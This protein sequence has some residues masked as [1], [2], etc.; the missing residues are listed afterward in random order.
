M[1]DLDIDM[2]NFGWATQRTKLYSL[3]Y[4]KRQVRQAIDDGRLSAENRTWVVHPAAN[5][6]VVAAIRARGALTHAS[7][8]RSFG[9]WVSEAA[10]D[11]HVANRRTDH[12]VRVPGVRRHWGEFRT[13]EPCHWRVRLVDAL[14]QYLPET[15]R[16]NAVATL[17]SALRLRLLTPSALDE[18]R[19]SL[20]RR[21]IGWL[22]EVDA[23]ADSGL[24]S[25]M[26]L[27]ALDQGWQVEIQ[28]PCDGERDDLVIDGWLHVEID[29][30]KWHHD[31]AQAKRDRKRNRRILRNGGRWIR[32]SY[33]D[34]M[35]N[36]DDTIE[37]LRSMLADGPPR[38]LSRP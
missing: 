8:L 21:C 26:R 1:R 3:G 20:P 29:G 38:G 34:V 23:R 13:D 10:G 24:E 36:L 18:L 35:H 11:V 27:A 28:V 33:A 22:D 19:L 32:L 14:L 37:L 9:I 31:E 12:V 2:K 16:Y 5:A 6:S 25:I 15:T 4:T 30:D 7:A 17:D